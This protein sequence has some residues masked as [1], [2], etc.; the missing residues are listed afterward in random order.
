MAT[1]MCVKGRT[2]EYKR[3]KDDMTEDKAWRG[4]TWTNI[5]PC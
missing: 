4:Q 1:D 2:G 5:K 3:G